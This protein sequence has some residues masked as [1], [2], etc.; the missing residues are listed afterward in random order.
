MN[1]YTKCLF[2]SASAQYF[3]LH[4][5][6]L[7]GCFPLLH[8]ISSYQACNCKA[9]TLSFQHRDPTSVL[10]RS[11]NCTNRKIPSIVLVSLCF[12]IS[13]FI[14]F[15]F[16][17]LHI[18]I[19]ETPLPVWLHLF[20]Q[21]LY[22]RATNWNAFP[23][24]SWKRGM[25]RTLVQ[26]AYLVCSTETYLKE[27]LTHLEKVFIEKNNYPKYVIN[28]VFT[29]VKEEHKN[30]NYNNNMRDSI[31]VPVTLENEIEKRHLP[32][33]TRWEKRLFN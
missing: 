26:H 6:H 24:I 5:R 27:E 18:P 10:T 17:S 9:S 15:H 28:Q 21:H 19:A 31:F 32:F 33:H 11:T 23:P 22:T 16:I 14:L 30:R 13:H 12:Y 20:I 8:F 1:N 3:F 29:Q 2:Y 7:Y 4:T 25:L